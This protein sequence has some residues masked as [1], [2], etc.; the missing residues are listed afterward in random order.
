MLEALDHALERGATIYA[1][2]LGYGHTSDAFHIT[3]PMES[4]EGA[5]KAVEFAL[6]DAGI[7]AADISYIN[8]HGTSTPLND[9]AETN[10]LKRALGETVYN[11]PVSSTKSMTGHLLG[12]GAAI[13]A[14]FSIMAIR[15]NFIPPTIHLNEPDPSCDLDY[16][17][18]RGYQREVRHVMSNAFGFG[19]HNAV[20]IFGEH[21]DNGSV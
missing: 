6:R 13:E 16:A 11:I 18:N 1:E 4:G 20:L 12:G 14:I 9:T 15:D 3:A 17:P 2:L 19:G 8:A 5:A 21:G 7:A 10:A